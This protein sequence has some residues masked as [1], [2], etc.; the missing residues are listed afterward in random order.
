MGENK[1]VR[2]MS[3]TQARRKPPLPYD[4]REGVLPG[5]AACSGCPIPIALKVV[6]AVFGEKQYL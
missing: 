2:D 1:E 6:S 5:D 3:T 4:Q